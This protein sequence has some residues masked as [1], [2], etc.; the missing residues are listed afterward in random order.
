MKEVVAN[1]E[2]HN[3]LQ[4]QFEA[5]KRKFGRNPGPGDPVFFDPDADV[6]RPYSEVQI[7]AMHE[8]LCRAMRTAGTDPALIHA[9][10]KTGRLVTKEN[11][12]NL[13]R[14]D[15]NEWQ[16]AIDEYRLQNPRKS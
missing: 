2:L 1:K 8:K 9:Y 3:A 10:N 7:E 6:P 4:T 11:M 13:S 14:A 5:F 16:D 15:L 12:R